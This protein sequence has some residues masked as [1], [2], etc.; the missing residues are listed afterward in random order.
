MG[1]EQNGCKVEDA[2]DTRT[3][4]REEQST[5][6]SIKKEESEEKTGDDKRMKSRKRQKIENQKQYKVRR[7]RGCL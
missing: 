1:R 2:K 4:R 3:L 7:S 6:E 5:Q